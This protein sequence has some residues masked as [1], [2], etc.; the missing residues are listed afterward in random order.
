MARS[1]EG[2]GRDQ[3]VVVRRSR[4]F[5]VRAPAKNVNEESGKSTFIYV[6]YMNRGRLPIGNVAIVTV[7]DLSLVSVL[8]VKFC[9]S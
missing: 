1:E 6:F 5:A 2:R 3:T 9:V 7:S 4:C 8:L